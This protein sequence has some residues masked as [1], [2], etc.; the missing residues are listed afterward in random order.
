M[1]AGLLLR[2]L[3][4]GEPV[5]FPHSRPLPSIGRQC[6]ELRIQ[7]ERVSWRLVYRLDRDA[8]LILEVF[9]KRTRKTPQRIIETCRAR[10][11]RYDQAAGE[12]SDG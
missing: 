10:L 11:Q 4:D 12:Q 8:V 3:Q 2:Q 7:D 6:H 5:G 9:E 1:E